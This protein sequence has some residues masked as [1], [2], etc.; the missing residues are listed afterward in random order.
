MRKGVVINDN[1]VMITRQCN[2]MAELLQRRPKN[3]RPKWTQMIFRCLFKHQ[4]FGTRASCRM[5]MI[6]TSALW[7][8]GQ[9]PQSLMHV[10]H[11][12]MRHTGDFACPQLVTCNTSKGKGGLWLQKTQYFPNASTTKVTRLICL[13]SKSFSM[14]DMILPCKGTDVMCVLLYLDHVYYIIQ[15]KVNSSFILLSFISHI[16]HYTFSV[17]LRW[18]GIVQ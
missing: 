9:Q 12:I 18:I 14:R 15:R 4:G 1:R 10:R 5:Q 3:R 8:H 11:F 2:A 17:L 16:F 13:L 6:I 7:H